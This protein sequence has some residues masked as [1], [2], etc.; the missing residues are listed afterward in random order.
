MRENFHNPE[1]KISSKI[2]LSIMILFLLSNYLLLELNFRSLKKNYVEV[3]GAVTAKIIESDASLER[4]IVP[5][6]TR[7]ITEEV[8]NKGKEILRQYGLS[9]D[10]ENFFFPYINKTIRHTKIIGALIF[11]AFSLLLF[12]LNLFQHGYFYRYIRRF[13]VAAR[14]I[15]EGEY[16][17]KLSEERE[18]DLSKLAVA[19]NSMG[20]VIRNHI[21]ALKKEKQFLADMLS[22]ISHQLKTPLSSMI[23]YNDIMLEKNLSQ[24]QR[25][26]FL[27]SNQKQ[28]S[29]MHN[30][31]YNLLKLAKLDAEAVILEKEEQNLFETVEE[32]LEILE[33]KA[34]EGKVEILLKG[35][36]RICF[37]HDRLW[38][39][40]AIIN[41]VKNAIEHT[42]EG[43]KVTLQV[44][45]SPVF[46]RIIIQDTGEGIGE[47]DI[48]NIFKRFYKAQNSRKSDSVGIGLAIA[49]SVIE[50]HG[51]FLEVESKEKTGTKFTAT[52][53]I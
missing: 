16:D 51:G 7:P 11:A 25:K 1:I 27:L 18:G 30:L 9:E 22:D 12:V 20:D 19:F 17:L 50:R 31:L 46:K 44:S 4:I 10:L 34:Q 15:V 35:D 24:E 37:N 42:P 38:L 2:L 45:E 33:G 39:Q 52:F 36:G 13:S 8:G 26:T 23:V 21:H 49:K 6:M 3:L 48:A 40:E 28:L 53:L 29:R 43:G 14:K 32:A 41:I 5:M 47:A